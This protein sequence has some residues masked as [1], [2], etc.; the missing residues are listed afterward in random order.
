MATP[1]DTPRRGVRDGNAFTSVI[2]RFLADAEAG[3]AFDSAGAAYSPARLRSLRRALAQ[4]E[5][6][7]GTTTL[8]PDELDPVAVEKLAWRV[9]DYSELA[10]I[11]HPTIVDALSGL[12]TYASREDPRLR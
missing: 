8:N 4:V 5:A 7:L 3:R 6:A 12:V 9:I 1:P 11:R 2:P 10:P